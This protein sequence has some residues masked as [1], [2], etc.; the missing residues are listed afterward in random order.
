[1]AEGDRLFEGG[2]DLLGDQLLLAGGGIPVEGADLV[3]GEA[4]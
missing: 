2:V 1:L 3:E 4:D